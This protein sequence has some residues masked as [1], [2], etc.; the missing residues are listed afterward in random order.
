M[1]FQDEPTVTIDETD[2]LVMV[3]A[4][5]VRFQKISRNLETRGTRV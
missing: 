1:R 3:A 4:S 2:G 5:I